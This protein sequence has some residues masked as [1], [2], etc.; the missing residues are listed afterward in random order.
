MQGTLISYIAS[1]RDRLSQE[2]YAFRLL[3]MMNRTKY[4]II[5]ISKDYM[6]FS[7]SILPNTIIEHR[8]SLKQ[9]QNRFMQ[10]N[11]YVRCN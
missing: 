8:T 5:L 1:M 9:C 2:V 10:L 7:S 4:T 11:F 6:V 3:L